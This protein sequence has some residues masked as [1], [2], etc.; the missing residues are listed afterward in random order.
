MSSSGTP[1]ARLLGALAV[2]ALAA[3]AVAPVV[4]AP[5]VSAQTV[6][7]VEARDSLIANQ[8]NLLNTYRCLFGVDTDVVPGECPN[9][10]QV[11][12]GVAPESPA[13]QD[14]D[15]RDEL[16]QN[17]EALLNV[18]RCRFDVDTQIV[19][20]GCI[21]AKP[22]PVAPAEAT[23]LAELASLAVGPEYGGPGYARADFDHDRRYL[24][25]AAGADPY[26]GVSYDP[27]TCD[28]D[29]IVA[30]AEAFESGA[31]QWDVSRR[32]AFGNDA[33]NLMAARDC[34]N[35]SKGARDI[36]EWSGRVASGACEGLAMTAR[37]RCYLAWKTVEAKAAYSLSV[38]RAEHDTLKQVLGGCPARGPIAPSEPTGSLP[39]AGQTPGGTAAET[40]EGSSGASDCHPAYDPCLPNLSGD[41]LNCGDLPSSLKPVRLRQIGVDPYRLDGDRDGIGCESG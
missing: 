19:P 23:V 29:H 27:G 8:E 12:P 40:P 5:A 26:T 36:A 32:R 15:V 18:Y 13:Q 30:A 37:G 20:G 4:S 9:P 11:S 17:Q 39:A 10:D 2:V 34:V 3:V 25:G 6:A 22:A 28:V 38:D 33:A 21:D 31:W 14:I 7:D 1:P 16:I 41:A 35:R 24:C